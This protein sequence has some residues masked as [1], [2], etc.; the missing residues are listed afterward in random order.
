MNLP[1]LCIRRPVMTTLLM[2][3]FMIFGVAGYR[4]LPVSALPK[5]DF[6]TISVTAKLPGASP[7]IMGSSVATPIEK[8]FA[9][10]A[11]ISSMTSTSVLGSTQIILQFDL[12][13]GIDGAALDVQSALSIAQRHL[14][15]TMPEPPSFRKVNPSDQPIIFLSFNSDTLPLS[16]VDDYAENNVAQRLSTLSGVAQVSV[17]GGQQYAVRVQVDPEAMAAHNIDFKT[18]Q[19]AVA[20]ATSNSPVGAL[21][22]PTQQLTLQATGLPQHAAD[23]NR[24]IVAYRDGA[25]I[26]IQDIGKPI[27]SVVNNLVA[28]WYNGKRSVVLA[29][30]R[31]PDAN[32]VQVVDSIR[33][34]LP[35]F[36]ASIPPAVNID[37]LADRSQSIRQSVEDVEMTL[38]LTTFLVVMVIF[39]FLRKASATLIPT[40]ALP[41]SV[42]G[43]FAGMVLCGF[44][45]NNISL[46]AL[47]LA[48][49]FVVDDAIVMLENIVRHIEE[50]EP[51]FEAAL[52]GS[53]EIGFTIISITF[54]L[55]AVFIP[56][57]F[58]GGVV[59]RVFR[60]F[61]MTISMA[62]LVSGFVSL[63]LTPMLCSRFLRHDDGSRE[64]LFGRI[65]E[66]GFQY[67]LSGYDVTLRLVLRYKFFML[68]VTLATIGASA[69]LF[70]A[71]PKGF[72]PAEDT[73]FIIAK[74]EGQQGLSF[75]AMIDVQQRAAAI[76]A[77][78]PAVEMTNSTVGDTGAA[79]T[80]NTGS[81]F[82]G[83][84]PFDQRPPAQAVIAR[85]RGK[86]AALPGI[87]VYMQAV[88]N[89]NIGG[90]QTKAQFQYTL[91]AG[92]L[93]E[94]YKWAGTLQDRIGRL[95]GVQ[96]VNTDMQI[97]T[98]QAVLKIDQ[99]RAQS[100]GIDAAT[101]R[102]T[103]YSAYGTRQVA[104]IF[105]PFNDYPVILEA[106]P[107]YQ[108]NAGGLKHIYVR[109]AVPTA[110][111][112]KLVPLDTFT[113]I[114]Q[115]VGPSS[116]NHQ[117][118][119]PSV[120]ISFNLAPGVALGQ[121]VDEI[122][123]IEHQVALPVTVT[124]SFQ[125]NA[126]VFQQATAGQGLLLATAIAVIY[127]IL[128]VLYESFIHPITILSGLPAA[129][130]GALLT[131]MLFHMDLSVIAM[132]GIVMLIGIVKKNAIMM[133]DFALQEK[134]GGET[135]PERA[136]Y[137]AAMLRFR[138][139][140]MT[141]M[142]CIMGTLPIA[143]GAGAGSELRRPL[144]VAVVGGLIVS[145][146]LTLYITPV[147]FLYFERLSALM[148]RTSSHTGEMP[149]AHGTQPAE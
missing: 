28:S 18:V 131:L 35:V 9:N 29:V 76:I 44:S 25:P 3:A 55:I 119:L 124:T 128:G 83:L 141:S 70:Q 23:Y 111:S 148:T 27:D 88:Q 14:P 116:I 57:L 85:L 64:N 149:T 127:I 17:Y 10:I 8:Q 140:M 66:G 82:I 79:S 144:G 92:D 126:Q 11:G 103:L 74:T 130:L 46:M 32:T 49:G 77:A 15:T 24:V 22:G 73:G 105:T 81:I 72:F 132:I 45:L 96:D 68:L 101:I 71:I 122:G 110:N 114:D 129:G 84:K 39:L 51:P 36:R 21:N 63:T 115:G 100:L 145:Q 59:G 48:V 90:R 108:E 138:P 69:Y 95:P 62:I 136:I 99:D 89:L 125:G 106:D 87:N 135:D 133:I 65:L 117:G 41:V 31:Q 112:G 7:E 6:P 40:L 118:Q 61:A 120:T 47:T 56:V 20:N 13:R 1:E 52:R 42:V 75:P 137:R 50:G 67:L 5:V 2:A 58:M 43:T 4:Q 93:G 60:E 121:A 30:Q 94:L 16:T 142:A 78:D 147:I 113:A 107:K 86:L 104:D 143:L 26:R 139:I 34:L 38:L 123:E 134:H 53:R 146:I 97:A 102:D 80:L 33:N 54:S 12:N 37:I 109:S 98:P 91:Q 19:T